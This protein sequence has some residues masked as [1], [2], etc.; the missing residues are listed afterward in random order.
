MPDETVQF[1]ISID[2]DGEVSSVGIGAS[3]P[4]TPSDYREAAAELLL[5]AWSQDGR[6]PPEQWSEFGAP[7][8]GTEITIQR[9]QESGEMTFAPVEDDPQE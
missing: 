6:F 7:Y 3:R 5:T 2:G 9:V 1:T 4:V 8:V